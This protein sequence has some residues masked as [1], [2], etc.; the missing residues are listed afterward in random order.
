MDPNNPVFGCVVWL[1]SEVFACPKT[2]GVAGLPKADW[3]KAD[4][5]PAPPENAPD[6]EPINIKINEILFALI[7]YYK[8]RTPK[9]HNI[10]TYEITNHLPN[11]FKSEIYN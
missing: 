2:A 3:P 11:I 10:S 4:V 5:F 7:R 8:M 6:P 9:N 1:N